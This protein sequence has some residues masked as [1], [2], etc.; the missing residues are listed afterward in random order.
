MVIE[1]IYVADSARQLQQESYWICTCM[2]SPDDDPRLAKHG[3]IGRLFIIKNPDW[4]LPGGIQI[5]ERTNFIGF[6]SKEEILF[7]HLKLIKQQVTQIKGE[8][9]NFIRSQE[10]N[11][12]G[13]KGPKH[14]SSWEKNN[15]EQDLVT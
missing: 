9:L 12:E 6:W 15:K 5:H 13:L 2:Y 14:V 11:E 3:I 10:I 1:Q 8:S 4:G 7:N